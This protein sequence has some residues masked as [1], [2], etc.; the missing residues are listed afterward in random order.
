MSAFFANQA[1]QAIT[2]VKFIP[3]STTPDL[4]PFRGTAFSF[5][6]GPS[7][8]R[9][10]SCNITQ[11]SGPTQTQYF[12]GVTD[13][14]VESFNATV[15]ATNGNPIKVQTDSAVL[16]TISEAT[17]VGSTLYMKRSQDG[18]WA[19]I[20]DP[21]YIDPVSGDSIYWNEERCFVALQSGNANDLIWAYR[22]AVFPNWSFQI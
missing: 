6:V 7:P 1:E 12:Y 9:A 20:V 19:N 14:S 11:I 3:A 2:I 15:H 22:I 21:G 4:L 10:A 8:T 18:K 5:Q 13:G 16:L 17:T